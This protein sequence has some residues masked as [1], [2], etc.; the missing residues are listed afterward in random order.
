MRGGTAGSGFRHNC[1]TMSGLYLCAIS[2]GYQDWL[3]QQ[4]NGQKIS[5][6]GILPAG[7]EVGNKI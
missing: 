3:A 4:H 6:V 5:S 1:P 2:S 7:E